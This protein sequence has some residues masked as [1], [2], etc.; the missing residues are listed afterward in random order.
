KANIDAGKLKLLAT[1]SRERL[2]DYPR[3]A[4]IAA[5]LPGVYADTWMAVAAPPGTPKEIAKKVS[6]AIRQGFQ[7]SE[8]RSRILALEGDPLASTPQEM[9]ELIHQSLKPGARW[10][11]RPRSSWNDS[12][13]ILAGDDGVARRL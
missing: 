4:T 2:K 7:E 12:Q 5:T 13:A 8:L 1:G 10:S 9:R 11:R 6:E 3:V